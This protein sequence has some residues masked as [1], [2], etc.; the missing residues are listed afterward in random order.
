[1]CALFKL[2]LFVCLLLTSPLATWVQAWNSASAVSQA[3]LAASSL[4][5]R[6]WWWSLSLWWWSSSLSLLS[7][8]Q[9]PSQ[10]FPSRPWGRFFV[11]AS[12]SPP[13]GTGWWW[14]WW[15]WWS[16]RQWWGRGLRPSEKYTSIEWAKWKYSVMWAYWKYTSIERAEWKYTSVEWAE[17]KYKC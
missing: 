11:G 1:M 8:F 13:P 15:P 9:Q 17:W 3:A 16:G 14:R 6:A 7:P 4:F 10:H 5:G 2:P 12:H